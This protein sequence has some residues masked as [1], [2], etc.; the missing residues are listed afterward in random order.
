MFMWR[1]EQQFVALG[2]GADSTPT[3]ITKDAYWT[4]RQ[5]ERSQFDDTQC[6]VHD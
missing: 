2:I 6:L 1:G 3:Y 4:S 5:R